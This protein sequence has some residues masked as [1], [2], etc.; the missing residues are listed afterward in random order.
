MRYVSPCPNTGCWFWDGPADRRGYGTMYMEYGNVRAHRVSFTLFHR[1]VQDDEFVLHSCDQP[2]CVNPDH[3]RAGGYKENSDDKV[4]RG[5]SNKGSR[6]P[7]SK[8]TEVDIPA[9]FEMHKSGVR[10][11]TI[12]QK[13]AVHPTTICDVLKGRRWGHLGYAEKE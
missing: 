11:S 6:H 10:G 3:L 9:I 8:L 13:Y 7:L 5:R 2:S 12:A 1:A 4:K